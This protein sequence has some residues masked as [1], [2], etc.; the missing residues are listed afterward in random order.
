M[1]RSEVVIGVYKEDFYAVVGKDIDLFK[2]CDL[3]KETEDIII[4]WWQSVRWFPGFL[5]GV[6]EIMNVLKRIEN[7]RKE[8]REKEA[9]NGEELLFDTGYGFLRIGEDPTDI[10]EE[11][12]L[13]EFGIYLN[14]SS[15]IEEGKKVK[16]EDFFSPNSIKFIKENN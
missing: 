13:Y 14:V 6:T 10:E 4:F 8:D 11:G 5:E 3:I 9:P 2:T 7:K 1:S 12:E 16:K 15:S